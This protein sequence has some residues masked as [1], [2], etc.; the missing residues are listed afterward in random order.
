MSKS[1]WHKFDPNDYEKEVYEVK[2][3]D[4]RVVE[5]YPNA[6]VMHD[7]TYNR[8]LSTNEIEEIKIKNLDFPHGYGL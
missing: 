5:G 1:N 7:L 8:V 3:K 4:G 6:G 2:L